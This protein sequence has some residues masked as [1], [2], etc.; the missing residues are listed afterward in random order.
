MN[1][2][3]TLLLILKVITPYVEERSGHVSTKLHAFE[4]FNNYGL[5]F[6]YMHV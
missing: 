2:F 5:L 3:K 1:Y 6:V 4:L